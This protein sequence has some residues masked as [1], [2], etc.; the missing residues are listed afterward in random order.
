MCYSMNSAGLKGLAIFALFLGSYFV[1][2]DSSKTSM[3]TPYSF[4][5][6]E[7]NSEDRMDF[8]LIGSNSTRSFLISADSDSMELTDFFTKSGSFLIFSVCGSAISSLIIAPIFVWPAKTLEAILRKAFT[9]HESAV[10]R[11]IF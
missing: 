1:E 7:D 4:L 6:R 11:T 9:F 5:I 10:Y 3:F 2:S 8:S